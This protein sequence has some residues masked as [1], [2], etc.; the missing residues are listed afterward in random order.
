VLEQALDVS[1][2]E[3]LNL[4]GQPGLREGIERLGEGVGLLVARPAALGPWLGLAVPAISEPRPRLLLAALRPQGRF[5]ELEGQLDLS[6]PLPLQAAEDSRQRSLL[7]GLVGQPTSLALVQD[8]AALL[9]QPLLAPLLRRAALPP[10][11]GRLPLLVAGGDGG[12]LLAALGEQGWLLGTPAD[13]PAPDGIEAALAAEGLIPAPLE[14]PDRT[15]LVWTRLSAEG[16]RQARRSGAGADQLQAS[17]AGW[18]AAEDGQAWWGSSLALLEARP[19]GAGAAASLLQ[20]LDALERPQA[21]LRW[22]LAAAPARQLLQPWRPWR[23]LTA[24]AGGG[25]EPPVRGLALALEADGAALRLRARLEL[26]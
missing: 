21:P 10:A 13:Q 9:A 24:L 23:Q 15:A 6:G 14:L 12:P 22:S 20:R 2:I 8:P 11:D 19:A 16:G 7:A 26:G 3:E 5:L 17:L 4:T 18:R 25:A 1:Q